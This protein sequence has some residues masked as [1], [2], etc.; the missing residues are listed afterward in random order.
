MLKKHLQLIIDMIPE[1]NTM[2]PIDFYKY[3]QSKP[4]LIE[5]VKN[6]LYISIIGHP[7]NKDKHY[8]YDFPEK[9]D[10]INQ[11]MTFISGLRNK[12]GNA[13]LVNES[14]DYNLLN[15]KNIAE[16][17]AYIELYG[18]WVRVIDS[19]KYY[20][21]FLYTI[22]NYISHQLI[23]YVDVL[24]EEKYPHYHESNMDNLFDPS[25]GDF[26]L[27]TKVMAYGKEN[28]LKE[29]IAKGYN[30]IQ[31]NKDV[32]KERYKN[33]PLIFLEDYQ[34]EFPLLEN[35]KNRN[36]IFSEKAL[37]DHSFLDVI[38]SK[39]TEFD[40][41]ISVILSAEKEKLREYLNNL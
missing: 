41:T 25:K 15:F 19:D 24:S 23:N 4:E 20:Y 6:K 32:F 10:L 27:D 36:Y 37:K 22:E 7:Y 11:I 38:D 28:E 9:V 35:E 13:I 31:N 1:F 21:S 39:K 18:T 26:L 16:F 12:E 33:E 5:Q 3:I 2:E 8:F 14:M 40:S 29:Y 17:N 30:Y 34:I